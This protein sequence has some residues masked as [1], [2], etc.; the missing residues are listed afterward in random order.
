LGEELYDMVSEYGA[1]V[2][3]FQFSKHKFSSFG[4]THN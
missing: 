2:F 1:I 3:G 4:L